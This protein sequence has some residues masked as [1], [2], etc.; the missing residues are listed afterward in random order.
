VH[1]TRSVPVVT[2]VMV[3]IADTHHRRTP[4]GKLHGAE[5]GHQPGPHKDATL[6]R[7]IL[8]FLWSE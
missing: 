6:A 1:L 3:T 2:G 4:P 7:G 8:G 5:A